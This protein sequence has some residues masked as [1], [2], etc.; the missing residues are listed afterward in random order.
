M[1]NDANT[2]SSV[3]LMQKAIVILGGVLAPLVIVF[4]MTRSPTIETDKPATSINVAENIKPLAVVEV[5]AEGGESAQRTGEEIS[6]QA[7]VACHGAGLMNSPA[8]GDTAAWATRI[9]QGYETL[10]KHA[11][12]GIRSMPARGGNADLTDIEVAKAVAYM[13]NQSGADFTPPEE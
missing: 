8:I 13:A 5:A 6:N 10:T 1:G 9:K 11:I 2:A 7:C 4:L 12:E 3:S